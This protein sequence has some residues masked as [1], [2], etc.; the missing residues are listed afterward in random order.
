MRSGQGR[1]LWQGIGSEFLR[2]FIC[3]VLW[4]SCTS[5]RYRYGDSA[6]ACDDPE[7]RLSGALGRVRDFTRR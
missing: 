1:E 4:E 2:Y 6:C 3:D 7:P 5:R